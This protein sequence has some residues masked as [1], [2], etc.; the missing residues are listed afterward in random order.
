MPSTPLPLKTFAKDLRMALGMETR[1][2]SR[3]KPQKIVPKNIINEDL[4]TPK[5][6]NRVIRDRTKYDRKRVPRGTNGEL[7]GPDVS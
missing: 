6:R 3:K 7:R 5:Y 4:M 2:V 1:E